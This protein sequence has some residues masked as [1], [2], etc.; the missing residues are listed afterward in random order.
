[1]KRGFMKE[2]KVYCPRCKRKVASWDGK[3]KI[4]VKVMCRNC[5]KTVLFHVDTKET[6][7]IASDVRGASSGVT[8]C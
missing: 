3:S 2:M 7:I 4:N 6:E 1:M 5:K 8:F